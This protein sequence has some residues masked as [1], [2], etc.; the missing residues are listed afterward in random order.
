MNDSHPDTSMLLPLKLHSALGSAECRM[1][2]P[3]VSVA[4][5]S[6]LRLGSP[7]GSAVGKCSECRSQEREEVE[8][9]AYQLVVGSVRWAVV[10]GQ[11]VVG[12]VQ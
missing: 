5:Q 4:S 3:V 2:T 11:C 6:W 12:S 7:V 1:L 8:A 9:L 10:N